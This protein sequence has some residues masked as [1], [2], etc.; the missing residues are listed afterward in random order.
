MVSEL[1]VREL[2]PIKK[3]DPWKRVDSFQVALLHTVLYKH[4]RSCFVVVI[5]WPLSDVDAAGSTA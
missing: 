1:Q 2:I 5:T 4:I 3:V